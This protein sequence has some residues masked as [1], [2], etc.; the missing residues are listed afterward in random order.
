MGSKADTVRTM[1]T[2]FS[3]G[4]LETVLAIFTD[5]IVIHVPGNNKVS[6]T[7]RGKGEFTE[8][9]L[10]KVMEITGGTFQLAEIRDVADSDKHAI[11][12]YTMRAERDGKV[13]E[14]HQAN[15]YHVEGDRVTEAWINPVEHEIFDQIFA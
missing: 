8:K 13:F 5:D 6:G 9:F 15:V 1:A 2:A 10:P 4:E 7:Y 14:Y 11:G 3:K 12:I